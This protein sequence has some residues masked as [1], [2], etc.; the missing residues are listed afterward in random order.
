MDFSFSAKNLYTNNPSVFSFTFTKGI[1][2][3]QRFRQRTIPDFHQTFHILFHSLGYIGDVPGTGEV[4]SLLRQLRPLLTDHLRL[5][6]GNA[7]Y[8]VSPVHR[9][10]GYAKMILQYLKQ[11]AGKMGL[12]RLLITVR[13]DNPASIRVALSCGG[14]IDRITDMRHYITFN[15]TR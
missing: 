8:S 2:K 1:V 7:G 6:G 3:V 14:S 4:R 13:N 5:A 10:K 12:D 9:G 11:E 15:L